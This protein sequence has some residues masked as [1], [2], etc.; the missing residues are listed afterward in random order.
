MSFVFRSAW[1]P[2]DID[3]L[4]APPPRSTASVHAS[5]VRQTASAAGGMLTCVPVPTLGPGE[6]NVHSGAP[7]PW[8]SPSLSG[9]AP[10]AHSE[11]AQW[12]PSFSGVWSD[13]S[14][15]ES[16]RLFRSAHTAPPAYPRPALTTPP[17]PAVALQ[18]ASVVAR[19]SAGK[20][21]SIAEH[22]AALDAQKAML[23]AKL[24]AKAAELARQ[25]S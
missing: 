15:A 20:T 11:P 6:G 17:Q 3:L 9:P 19:V 10:D 18:L 8:L 7:P 24:R 21:V 12:L 23:R 2:W 16:A 25:P 1:E 4:D 22:D 5:A 13:G 14:R